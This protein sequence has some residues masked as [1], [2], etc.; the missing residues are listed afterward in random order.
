MTEKL[1]SRRIS[2]PISARL[3]CAIFTVDI[4]DSNV[5]ETPVFAAFFSSRRP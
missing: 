5:V 1:E 3:L 4:R 2:R